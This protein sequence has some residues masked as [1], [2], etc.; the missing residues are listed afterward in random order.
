ML[1][2]VKLTG[3]PRYFHFTDVNTKLS[4]PFCASNQGGKFS[5]HEV[6]AYCLFYDKFILFIEMLKCQMKT[7]TEYI[8]RNDRVAKLVNVIPVGE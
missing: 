1:L 3:L 8:F 5:L 7:S 2:H 6:Q 4:Q